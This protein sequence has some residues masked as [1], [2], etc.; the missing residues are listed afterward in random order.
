LFFVNTQRFSFAGQPSYGAFS[1][2]VLLLVYAFTGFEMAGIPAGEIRDPQRTLPAAYL[3]AIG[4]VA[5]TYI[6]IQAVCI[7]T[8]PELA[9][10]ERPLADAGNRFLGT[11]G[12][13]I[14]SAGALVSIVGN[15]NLVLLAGSRLPFAMAERKELPQIFAVTHRRFKTPFYAILLTA[16]VVLVLTISGTFIYAVT[17]ST[18]ARL[19]SY[20]ATCAALPLLRRRKESAPAMF[21]APAGIA[22]SVSALALIAWLLSNITL[23]EARDSGIAAALGLVVYVAYRFRRTAPSPQT[24]ENR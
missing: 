24:G 12:A 11:S 21:K 16:T 2:S 22:V 10:S 13:S 3:T 4:A 14:I 8:L 19:V 9:G 20:G 7:G 5:L 15:L 17:I 18:I 6:L 1:T 23:R